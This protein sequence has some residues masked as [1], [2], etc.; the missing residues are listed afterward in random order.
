MQ[1]SASTLH[2]TGEAL[3]LVLASN[4]PRRRLLL[5]SLGLSFEVDPGDVEEAIDDGADVAAVVLQLALAKAREVAPRYGRALIVAADTLVSLDGRALGKPWDAADAAR[6]LHLLSGRDHR[7]FTGL[8]LLDARSM[9]FESRVV[10]SE[11]WFRQLSDTEIDAYVSTEEP[12]DKA[13]SYGS[14]GLGSVF[15]DKIAGD[16]FNVVGLPLAALNQLLQAAGC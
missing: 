15:I 13:G 4:S 1:A 2:C 7:V 9:R 14:Q 3:P 6:M 10:E 5:E 8:V 11:V 12:L 16:Y